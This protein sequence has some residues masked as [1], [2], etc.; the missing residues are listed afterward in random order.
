MKLKK[1]LKNIIHNAIFGQVIAYMNVIQF[2]KHGLPHA[3]ILIILD[4]SIELSTVE[5]IY[6]MFSAE[7][8]DPHVQKVF[9]DRVLHST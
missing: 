7:I 1:L 8:P 3:C 2:H 9:F 6:E 4:Q 5:D